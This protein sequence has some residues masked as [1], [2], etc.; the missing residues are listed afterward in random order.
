MIPIFEPNCKGRAG[1][2]LNDY[3]RGVEVELR[4]RL[5]HVGMRRVR[6]ALNAPSAPAIIGRMKKGVRKMSRERLDRA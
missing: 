6:R 3:G 4:L 1:G 5:R 2:C